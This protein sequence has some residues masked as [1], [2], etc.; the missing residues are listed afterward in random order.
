M[1]KFTIASV[2]KSVIIGSFDR[3]LQKNFWWGIYYYSLISIMY[4]IS[5]HEK[6]EVNNSTTI[7]CLN[8]LVHLCHHWSKHSISWKT[9]LPRFLAGNR[10]VQHQHSHDTSW[11]INYVQQQHANRPAPAAGTLNPVL[12]PSALHWR[13]TQFHKPNWAQSIADFGNKKQKCSF[14]V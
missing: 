4:E 3:F 1:D 12:S 9:D 6:C 10:A 8:K 14:T 7:H 2:T 5:A 11:Q 13:D